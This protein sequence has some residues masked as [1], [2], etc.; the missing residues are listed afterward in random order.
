VLVHCAA[1]KDRT[2]LSVAL[3][4]HVA[5]VSRDDMLAN[6]LQ[7]NDAGLADAET[8]QRVR[9]RFSAEGRPISDETILAVLSVAPEYLHAMLAVI[10]EKCGSLDRYIDESLGVTAQQRNEI[11]ARF[12]A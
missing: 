8:M 12:T 11:V 3:A 10:D 2:G 1:G 5:G 9:E 4:H 6:Y 7:S